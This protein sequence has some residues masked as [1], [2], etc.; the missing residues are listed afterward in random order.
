[1]VRQ[2][3]IR[4]IYI[5]TK[6]RLTIQYFGHLMR[7]T[8]SSEKTPMLGKIEGGRRREQQRVGWLDGITDV[9]DMSLSRLRELVMDR[10][11]W[12]AVAHGVASSQTRLSNWTE[13]NWAGRWGHVTCSTWWH[14]SR[15]NSVSWLEADSVGLSLMINDETRGSKQVGLVVTE[16]RTA[17]L[18][19]HPHSGWT[20]SEN[21][22][23]YKEW[24]DGAVCYSC[25]TQAILINTLWSSKLLCFSHFKFRT[26][27]VKSKLNGKDPD[28]GKDW[29]QEEK[30]AT[31]DEMV[32]WH[33]QFNGKNPRR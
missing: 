30:R 9:M 16:W 28:A 19:S 20:V 8:D 14:L 27:D 25:I 12:R 17:N 23:L 1:M 11:A 22:L 31:E 10:E 33:H 5:T 3:E 24:D 18:K 29:V 26:P 21:L 4:I 2:M 6:L 15:N 7:R 13:L 32:G